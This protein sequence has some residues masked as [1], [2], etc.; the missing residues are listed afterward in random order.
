MSVVMMIDNPN[1][2]REIYERASSGMSLP[3]G[4]RVHLAGPG[5]DGGW[6]VIEVWASEEEARRFLRDE[7]A[8]AL[9]AAGAQGPPPSPQFWPLYRDA[10]ADV[11]A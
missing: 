3:L 2:S 8:P 11:P 5:P 6:R 10:T 4:G 7:L 9:R 1:G